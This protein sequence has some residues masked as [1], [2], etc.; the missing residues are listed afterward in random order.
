[1]AIITRDDGLITTET[2]YS[3]I[4]GT[5]QLQYSA[6]VGGSIQT[7][8]INVDKVDSSQEIAIPVA[9]D[10][11]EGHRLLGNSIGVTVS[12]TVTPLILLGDGITPSTVA[13]AVDALFG[14]VRVQIKAAVGDTEPAQYS[15]LS[16]HQIGGLVLPIGSIL[17]QGTVAFAEAGTAETVFSRNSQPATPAAGDILTLS[18][19]SGKAKFITTA[20]TGTASEQATVV[21]LD[22]IRYPFIITETDTEV[23][24][25]LGNS[26]LVGAV[27]TP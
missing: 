1:M 15:A 23:I 9:A 11:F 21:R 26:V 7:I 22:E 25:L 14:K 2:N 24:E 13:M 10:T 4:Q 20:G 17:E 8:D 18:Y 12:R 27:T 5:I 19:G 6:P 3:A 16:G